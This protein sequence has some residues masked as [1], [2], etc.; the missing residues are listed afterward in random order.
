MLEVAIQTKPSTPLPTQTSQP[1]PANKKRKRDLKG[2]DV[3]KEGEVIP[4]K[5]IDPQKGAKISRVA[6]MRP[7]SEEAIVVKGLD[8]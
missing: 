1:D 8:C 7:S 6:Q 3:A 5:E 4:S 2:K